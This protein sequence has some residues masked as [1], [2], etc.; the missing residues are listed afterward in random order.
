MEITSLYWLYIKLYFRSRLEY[1][2]SYWAGLI[3]NFYTYFMVYATF[4]VITKKYKT[5]GGWN[6]QEISV[7]YSLNLL[8]YAISGTLLWY[9]VYNLEQLVV[10]GE[11]DRFLLRPLGV[12]P[13]LM[14]QTFGYTFLGQIGVSLFFLLSNILQIGTVFSLIK[15]VYLLF[16]IAGG[17]LI[18]AGGMIFVGSLSF[19]VLRSKNIGN[20]VY[21][22]F[23]QF[24]NYPLTIFPVYVKT[25]LTYVF[26]WAFINYYPG[27]L[28][29]EKAE[30]KYDLYL[31]SLSPLIGL[32]FF[33]ASLVMFHISIKHY[34]STG[35]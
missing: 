26:P 31:G 12:L 25:I 6:F 21:Y 17:V 13:Q 22:N 15:Y 28:L 2:S 7:L 1:R 16:A 20:I 14:C 19:W 5:L 4:W 35:S 32:L 18:Q 10:S 11:F 33:Y 34:N 29:L 9:S 3:A 27:M 8:T 24:V 30:N 23:R